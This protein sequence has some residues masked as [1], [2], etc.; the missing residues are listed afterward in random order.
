MDCGYRLSVYAAG[1]IWPNMPEDTDM[2]TKDYQLSEH[3]NLR[4]LTRS[5]TAARLGIYNLPSADVVNRLRDLCVQVL[6]PVRL[7]F[8]TPI[9]PDS[10]YRSQALNEAIGGA[11]TSQHCKGEAVDFEVPYVSNYD[12]AAWIRDNLTFDQL[13]LEC[14]IVGKPHSGWVHVSYKAGANRNEVLT[15]TG[16]RY[17]PGLVA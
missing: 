2:E 11:K 9:M 17:L 4:E 16:G 13:I 15:Y 8:M 1:L 5:Q 10:G 7:H 12:L 3:F 6:E 14:Y